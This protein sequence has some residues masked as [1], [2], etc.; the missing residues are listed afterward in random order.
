MIRFSLFKLKRRH[1]LFFLPSQQIPSKS[2]APTKACMLFIWKIKSL[3]LRGGT[4]LHLFATRGCYF[5]SSP[6]KEVFFASKSN[7]FFLLHLLPAEAPQIA[8]Q[9]FKQAPTSSENHQRG[10]AR[11]CP[12][13]K[14][15]RK[16]KG[17]AYCGL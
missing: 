15:R 17:G 1:S 8:K 2:P 7:L 9:H 6:N 5:V 4:S 3:L 14:G 11:G 12:A 10:P 13:R 16:E